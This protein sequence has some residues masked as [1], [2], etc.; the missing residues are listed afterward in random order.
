MPQPHGYMFS[1]ASHSYS[2]ACN[3]A[4]ISKLHQEG[5]EFRIWDTKDKVASRAR[6]DC[7]TMLVSL[8]RAQAL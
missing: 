4:F 1:K 5:M 2:V 7:G 8:R 6:C 3:Q